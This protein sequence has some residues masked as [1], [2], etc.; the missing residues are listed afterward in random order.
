MA[1]YMAIIF[2]LETGRDRHLG[3]PQSVLAVCVSQAISPFTDLGSGGGPALPT[4]ES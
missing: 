1:M 3:L 2:I 4:S